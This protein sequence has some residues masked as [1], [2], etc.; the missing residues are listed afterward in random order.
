MSVAF[1]E[2]EKGSRLSPSPSS[3][4]KLAHDDPGVTSRAAVHLT[5]T[6]QKR[7]ASRNRAIV[8]VLSLTFFSFLV[9]S[10]LLILFSTAR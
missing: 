3:K 7:K 1:V 4:Q 9:V 8:P 10:V 6:A 2:E 5:R